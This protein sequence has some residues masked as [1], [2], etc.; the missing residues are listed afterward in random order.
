MTGGPLNESIILDLNRHLTRVREV[1]DG[2][3]VTEPGV[4]YRDFEAETLR[5]DQLMPS[6]PASREIC[7]VGN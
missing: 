7:T 5:S 3:A 6:Y 1:G 4:F 2:F